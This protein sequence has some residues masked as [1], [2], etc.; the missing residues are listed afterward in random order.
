MHLLSLAG[1]RGLGTLIN[2]ACIV[3]GGL[4]G[5]L[6]GGHLK[7]RMRQTLLA[8]MGVAVVFLGIG[9]AVERMLSGGGALM[10][11]LSLAAGA[12]LGELLDLDGKI[13][14]F[15]VFLREKSNSGGDNRFVD[16]FVS[17]S[18]TVCIGAMAVVGA[19]Q[20]GTGGG[21]STLTVKGLIDLVII[22]MMTAAQGKGCIFSAIPVALFQGLVTLLAA[23]IGGFLPQAALDNLSFVGS[24]LIF[25]VGLNLLREQ[26]LRVANLLPAIL[27]AAA[28][29]FFQ[30]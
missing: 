23:L 14:R 12:V 19:I 17:A 11:I 4:V 21:A 13:E 15:G 2:A 28:W 1:I 18:C 26:K 9:G 5:L 16:A 10:M 24:I 25:C 3:A 7:A 6:F 20:D 22:C 27:I 8:A 29:G 30:A